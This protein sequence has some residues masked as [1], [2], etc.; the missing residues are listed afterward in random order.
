MLYKYY[1][2]LTQ[3]NVNLISKFSVLKTRNKN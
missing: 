2:K 3:G 1:L